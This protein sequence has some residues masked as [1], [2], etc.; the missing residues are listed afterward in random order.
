MNPSS[1]ST[2]VVARPDRLGDVV[3]S[4]SCLPAVRS[5]L[6]HANLHW[7]VDE[8]FR[9]LFHAHPLLN[10][11]VAS[12][13][14]PLWRRVQMLRE[15]LRRLRPDALVLL[16]PNRA[17]ELA[18]RLEQ[19]PVR[20]GFARLRCWPQFLTEQTPYRKSLG[21]EHESFQNFNALALIGV[22]RPA[23]LAPSLSPD[24]AA[25]LRLRP[26]LGERTALLPRCAALHLAA[27]GSKLR[28]PLIV[29]ARLTAWLRHN[30][31][32][33]VVLVGLETDPPAAQL[34]EL[35]GVDVAG[36]IDLRGPRDVAETAWLLSSVPLCVARDSGPAHLAAA[37]GCPTLVLFPDNR[38]IA[39]PA[40]WRPL[41]PHV[42]TLPVDAGGEFAP[43]AVHAAAARLL[44]SAGRTTSGAP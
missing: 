25:R 30:H 38:P 1:I 43:S 26:Q 14:G 41:G 32:L 18:A 8:R 37:L 15:D 29:F 2:L 34:A 5:Q 44:Q 36:I 9:S 33:G 19:I 28:A 42:E 20:A 13:A 35:A 27:H 21:L 23:Q 7:L 4:S 12:G 40:R 24:P 3:L 10:G 6:P 31:R 17:V 39:G 16:Q 22:E 11:V